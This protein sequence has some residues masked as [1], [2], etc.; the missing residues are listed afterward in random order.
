MRGLG[1][2]FARATTQPSRPDSVA[3][4]ARTACRTQLAPPA[5]SYRR[6]TPGLRTPS[7]CVGAPRPEMAEHRR[8]QAWKPNGP[9]PSPLAVGCMDRV[10]R[11]DP[12]WE[13]RRESRPSGDSWGACTPLSVAPVRGNWIACRFFLGMLPNALGQTRKGRHETPNDRDR[14][15]GALPPSRI[16]APPSPRAPSVETLALGVDMSGCCL[17]RACSVQALECRTKGISNSGRQVRPL[18]TNPCSNAVSS[19]ARGQGLCAFSSTRELTTGSTQRCTPF[20]RAAARRS[21]LPSATRQRRALLRY[22][23]GA[24]GNS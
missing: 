15:R 17:Q 6:P 8:L 24:F 7:S 19:T 13:C 4:A 5:Y 3:R 11:L 22:P 10:Q 2:R 9:K 12:H 1:R 14:R 18:W 21:P 16:H 20:G 23:T